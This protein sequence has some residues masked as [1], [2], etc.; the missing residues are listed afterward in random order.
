M[1]STNTSSKDTIKEVQSHGAL[2]KL[3]S[4]LISEHTSRSVHRWRLS[5]RLPV[6]WRL[7]LLRHRPS[8]ENIIPGS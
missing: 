8:R 7:V 5:P 4:R 2:G 6:W 1:E 3:I